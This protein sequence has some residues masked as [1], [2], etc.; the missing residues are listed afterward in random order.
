[1]A[2]NSSEISAGSQADMDAGWLNENDQRIHDASVPA[3][4]I[5]CGIVGV[6]DVAIL[7]EE[8]PSAV[9]GPRS[10]GL[11]PSRNPLYLLTDRR[12]HCSGPSGS[13]TCCVVRLGRA[14]GAEASVIERHCSIAIC[15]VGYVGLLSASG[16]ISSSLLVCL[17]CRT[18]NP[19]T[20]ARL[21]LGS[22]P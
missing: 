5:D 15:R 9:V 21:S 18:R 19:T 12:F 14:R 17:A 1:M 8:H 13:F 3:L 2:E 4:K 20:A 6:Y 22:V 11:K 7:G 10:G 16:L